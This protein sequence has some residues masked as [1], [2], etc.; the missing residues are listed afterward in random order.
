M[1]SENCLIIIPARLSSTRLPNKPILKIA[2]QSLINRMIN[3]ALEVK[4]YA[5]LIVATDSNEIRNE[6]IKFGIKVVMTSPNHKNGTERLLEVISTENAP[7]VVNLQCDEPLLDPED[8][9]KLIFEIKKSNSDVVSLCFKEPRNQINDPSSVKVVFDKNNYALYFSRNQIPYNSDFLH[10]HAGIY[11]FTR[12]A[13]QKIKSLETSS[14]EKLENL[15]QLRW[16]ENGLKIKMLITSNKLI[17]VDTNQDLKEAEQKINYKKIKGIITDVDGV[18]TNG[19]LYYGKA[20]EELKVFNVKD[21]LALKRFM[22]N[23]IKIA[24]CSARSSLALESRIKDLGI[25]FFE[26][27]SKNKVLSC[28]KLLKKMNLSNEDVCYIGDDHNDIAPMKMMGYG[29]AV[30]DANEELKNVA[31]EVFKTEGGKGVFSELFKKFFL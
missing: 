21:G 6:V 12:L 26:I 7:Y 10:I 5:S 4:E 28:N 16:I 20:G 13:L 2:G 29:F 22:S 24:I 25:E 31:D 3:I 14:L 17:G 23:D 19:Q 9:K 11:G 15:E 1:N 18:L 30:S 8:L 27:G